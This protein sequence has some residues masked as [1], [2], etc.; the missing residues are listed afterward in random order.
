ML[1]LKNSYNNNETKFDSLH[2]TIVDYFI[3]IGEIFETQNILGNFA[4]WKANMKFLYSKEILCNLKGWPDPNGPLCE[5][6][7]SS[8]FLEANKEEKNYSP[9]LVQVPVYRV[10]QNHI[11]TNSLKK[12]RLWLPRKQQRMLS[13]MLLDI[14]KKFLDRVLKES[15]VHTWTA[16]YKKELA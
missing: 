3:T 9:Q 8:L 11:N 15:N 2:L 1:Y 6:V 12:R 7:P 5:S 13:Q 4:N 14:S 10:S 16:E